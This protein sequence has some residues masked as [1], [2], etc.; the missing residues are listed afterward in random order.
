M[1]TNSANFTTSI[2]DCACSWT[3]CWADD[4]THL[5]LQLQK[6]LSELQ[7]SLH[8]AVNEKL[9]VDLLMASLK[10]DPK[11]PIL[12]LCIPFFVLI[13][14]KAAVLPLTKLKVQWYLLWKMSQ[15]PLQQLP[16]KNLLQP[17]PSFLNR[18]QK[19]WPFQAQLGKSMGNQ[20]VST[21][22]AEQQIFFADSSDYWKDLK[23]HFRWSTT[24]QTFNS[25]ILWFLSC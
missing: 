14:S 20:T 21:P 13:S 9:I 15:S 23:G 12:M 10:K 11:F 7:D 17:L 1:S 6:L 18:K 8:A 25:G 24:L 19:K 22:S 3:G 16:M 5:V 2:L 4:F